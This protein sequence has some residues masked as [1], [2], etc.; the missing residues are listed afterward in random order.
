MQ[1][2]YPRLAFGLQGMAGHSKC[3]AVSVVTHYFVLSC[4]F[5]LTLSRKQSFYWTVSVCMIPSGEKI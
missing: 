1:W 3:R 5:L 4:V 2:K